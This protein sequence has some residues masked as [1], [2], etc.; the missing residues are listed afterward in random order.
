MM[1]ILCGTIVLLALLASF[2][3]AAPVT[4]AQIREIRQLFGETSHG[5]PGVSADQVDRDFALRMYGRPG[6]L[7]ALERILA[8]PAY[9]D[10]NEKLGQVREKAML[11]CWAEV[12]AETGVRIELNNAGK[13]NGGRSDLDV[14]V[15][16]DADEL[17]DE[18]GR[19]I[20]AEEVHGRLVSLFHEKWSRRMPGTSAADWDIM[21]FPG[22]SMMIDWRMSKSSWRGFMAG[23]NDDIAALSAT[24]GAYFIPGAYKDQVFRRYLSEGRTT[25]IESVADSRGQRHRD[26][27]LPDGVRITADLPTREASLRYAGVPGDIDRR[28]ALGVVLQNVVETDRHAA[29]V[30]KRAKYSNRWI[31]GYVQ[32]TN[33]EKSYQKLLLEGRDGAR[34]RF[35]RRLFAEFDDSGRLPPNIASADE[36]MRVLDTMNRIELDKVLADMPPESRPANWSDEWRNYRTADIAEPGTKLAYFAAEAREMTAAMRAASA[37]GVGMEEKSVADLAEGMFMDKARQAARMAAASAAKRAMGDLFTRGGAARAVAMHGSDAAARLIVER[38]KGLHAAFVFLNDETMMRAIVA[39][40]PPEARGAVDDLVKIARAQRQEILSRT[41]AV[42]KLKRGQM[43]ESDAVVARL[44]RDLGIDEAELRRVSNPDADGDAVRQRTK[45]VLAEEIGGVRGHNTRRVYEFFR[46]DLPRLRTVSGFTSQYWDNVCDIGTVTALGQAFTAWYTGDTD[47]ASRELVFAAVEGV[48]VAGKLFSLGRSSMAYRDGSGGPLLTFVANQFLA[49]V[50]GGAKYAA[51]LGRILCIYGLQESLYLLGWYL[52][53]EPA[54]AD[55]VSLVLMGSMNSI[56]RA[57]KQEE[58]VMPMIR[59]DEDWRLVQEHAILRKNVSIPPALQASP[60]LREAVLRA[61]FLPLA[62]SKAA[63]ESGGVEARETILKKQF[64]DHWEY[65]LRRILFFESVFPRVS[66]YLQD[67]DAFRQA[68]YPPSD[69]VSA[70]NKDEFKAAFFVKADGSEVWNY[71]EVY[72][73]CYFRKMLEEWIGAQREAGEV[74]NYLNAPFKWFFFYRDWETQVVEELVSYYKEGELFAVARDAHEADL[75]ARLDTAEDEAERARIMAKIG[76]VKGGSDGTEAVLDKVLAEEGQ[77]SRARQLTLEKAYW[78]ERVLAGFES[79]VAR[80]VAAQEPLALRE[81]GVR[82]E[83]KIPRPVG[84][85]GRAIPMELAVHGDARLVPEASSLNVALEYRVV[86]ETR[87]R[88]PKGV[89]RDD[90][91][92][93]FGR[94]E[95]PAGLKFT[96]HELTVRLSSPSLPAFRAEP[97]MRRVFW[98]ALDD[99]ADDRGSASQTVPLGVLTALDDLRGMEDE[100]RRLA[101]EALRRCREGQT[102]VEGLERLIGRDEQ[103]FGQWEAAGRRESA[104]A[105]ART[106]RLL[107]A[108]HGEVETM[109]VRLGELSVEAGNK[110]SNICTRRSALQANGADLAGLLQ[111]LE[112]DHNALSALSQGADTDMARLQVLVREAEDAAGILTGETSMSALSFRPLPDMSD[113]ERSDGFGRATAATGA[114][115]EA[116]ERIGT[117]LKNARTVA[118]SSGAADDGSV[119]GGIRELLAKIEA[120]LAAASGCPGLVED[121]LRTLGQRDSALRNRVA[122]PS[123]TDV[124]DARSGPLKTLEL[125]R[126]LGDL[127]GTYHGRIREAVVAAQTCRSEAVSLVQSRVCGMLR[128]RFVQALQQGAVQQARDVAR[129]AGGCAWAATAQSEIAQVEAGLRCRTLAAELDAACRVRDVARIR[130]L[131][132]QLGAASCQVDASLFYLAQGLV[133]APA[134]TTPAHQPGADAPVQDSDRSKLLAYIDGLYKK[135]SRLWCAGKWSGCDCVPLGARGELRQWV[136]DARTQRQ[137][138]RLKR[139]ADC[140]DAC[141]MQKP[142]SESRVHQCRLGCKKNVK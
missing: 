35:A 100:A 66:R 113:R 65:W 1:V 91:L 140:Y 9:G 40:M 13:R 121:R 29:S 37:A 102:L 28:G 112:G 59:N 23:M 51:T 70:D 101:E 12:V 90:I 25:I 31:E 71:E 10:I 4:D 34:R 48:P 33:L 62:T 92:T 63:A 128:E 72:L 43:A 108:R 42:E 117:V 93:L 26:L 126:L 68:S 60:E 142:L 7:G 27:D 8:G 131:L 67:K 2:V 6:A 114:A 39:E 80:A 14:F 109:T 110:A 54:Q 19:A 86:S 52:Y 134:P 38:V 115:R 122:A 94:D 53:G 85:P 133:S 136:Q 118:A 120:H 124:R 125:I 78:Q 21:V 127:A 22:D 32:L 99:A 132:A 17:A 104:E 83:L 46:R 84:R 18:A 111:G 30:I 61:H 88:L 130:F 15:F 69:C 44:L 98:V 11:E 96:E 77:K 24:E 75:R 50:P 97:V 119:V 45:M 20:P 49:A 58:S 16:T 36:L 82:V 41:S 106:G 47:K 135:W 5:V 55:L 3:S 57:L 103:T 129:Q 73:R 79:S 89:L 105:S 87:G 123:F 95:D 107:L 81:D 138:E 64:F 141:I 137:L 74:M 139:L 116:A 76:F 56:P